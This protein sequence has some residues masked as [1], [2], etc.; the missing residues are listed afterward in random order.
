MEIARSIKHKIISI[1]GTY[2]STYRHLQIIFFVG[3]VSQVRR[4]PTRYWYTFCIQC[5]WFAVDD[6]NTSNA[7]LRRSSYLLLVYFVWFVHCD[8]ASCLAT[9]HS[10]SIL[11]KYH[12]YLL[13]INERKV[14]YYTSFWILQHVSHCISKLPNLRRH[15]LSLGHKISLL[16]VPQKATKVDQLARFYIPISVGALSVLNS[17][18]QWFTI[19]RWKLENKRLGSVRAALQTRIT[20][21]T[22]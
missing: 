16:L 5:T 21:S 12:S 3:F 20:I 9:A 14:L 18:G 17:P 19:I 15:L 2:L 13:F 6:K 10:H 11:L 8:V 1:G 4:H 22:R 7:S